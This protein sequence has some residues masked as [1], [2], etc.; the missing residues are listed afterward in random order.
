VPYFFVGGLNF[1]FEKT[2]LT[3]GGG[4]ESFFAVQQLIPYLTLPFFALLLLAACFIKLP[5]RNN[6]FYFYPLA[7]F[8]L[9]LIPKTLLFT[10][11]FYPMLPF[12]FILTAYFITDINKIWLK[13]TAYILLAL[14]LL[15]N[16]AV[17]PG[18]PR[19][20]NQ[21]YFTDIPPG[22]LEIKDWQING[23]K[24]NLP[25]FNQPSGSYWVYSGKFNANDTYDYIIMEYLDENAVEIIFDNHSIIDKY[26]SF[27]YSQDIA[28][29]LIKEGNHTLSFTVYNYFNIGGIGQVQS[30]MRRSLKRGLTH[31]QHGTELPFL[32][33]KVL[34]TQSEIA[35]P[36]AIR[37]GPSLRRG[38]PLVFRA[39]RVSKKPSMSSLTR[40]SGAPCRA[41]VSINEETA[42]FAAA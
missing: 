41:Q 21:V 20:Y 39:C 16:L 4:G 13:I 8:L 38:Q 19:M 31:R 12:M 24:A 25:F 23:E 6:L 15:A 17:I 3:R 10:R 22:C 42:R 9:M 11:H 2:T 18:L 36:P 5:E 7:F 29:N 40:T 37:L 34:P 27:P 33:A 1:L 26:K 32:L 35:L 14:F 30:R 28:N